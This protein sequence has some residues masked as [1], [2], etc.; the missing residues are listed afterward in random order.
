MKDLE[1]AEAKLQ[2]AELAK[3]AAA[4][5]AGLLQ[6]LRGLLYALPPDLQIEPSVGRHPDRA[7]LF[8]SFKKRN[9]DTPPRRNQL[10]NLDLS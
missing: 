9:V 2:E 4:A 1:D 8:K 3:A 7:R 5:A 10:G 6:F